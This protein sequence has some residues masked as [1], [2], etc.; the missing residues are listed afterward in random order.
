MHTYSNSSSN[1]GS[2]TSCQL[3]THCSLCQ[4]IFLPARTQWLSL[5]RRIS[6][7]SE[8]LNSNLF[9]HLQYLFLRHLIISVLFWDFGDSAAVSW[10]QPLPVVNNRETNCCL[11]HSTSLWQTHHYASAHP[12]ASLPQ[13]KTVN[14]LTRASFICKM[15][16]L[17]NNCPFLNVFI[18]PCFVFPPQMSRLGAPLVR[19][20]MR[21]G[22]GWKPQC[23]VICLINVCWIT[24][25][26][27]FINISSSKTLQLY[28]AWGSFWA[29]RQEVRPLFWSAS[30]MF[31]EARSQDLVWC[32]TWWCVHHCVL[33]S[34]WW[35]IV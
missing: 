8:A 13:T 20:D 34:F 26:A 25:S 10:M 7:R 32:W 29:S 14:T 4:G 21:H 23:R 5:S 15:P 18:K 22:Q 2:I 33:Q 16:I 30:I 9:P 28:L 17:N 1:Y 31:K 11:P 27:F 24:V 6:N 12:Q 3:A 35:Q 19:F